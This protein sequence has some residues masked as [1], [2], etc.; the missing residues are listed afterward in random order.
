MAGP[1]RLTS[2]LKKDVS[3]FS[4]LGEVESLDFVVLR[5]PKTNRG[6]E[7]LQDDQRADDRQ[8]RCGSDPD[9]LID[10]LLDTAF[11]EAVDLGVAGDCPGREHSRE[12]RSD[13]ASNSVHPERIERV[14]VSEA[15]LDGCTAE[16]ADVAGNEPE[17]DSVN[18]V[19]GTSR[20]SDADQ[21]GRQPPNILPVCSVCRG[22][23]IPLPTTR[24]R[25]PLPPDASR[26]TRW[27]RRHWRRR[28]CRR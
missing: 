14:V 24:S 6:I 15:I 10:E 17:E 19:D 4:V 3:F 1:N 20:G 27:R 13:G 28:R 7:N 25:H 12:Q 23:A 21:T 5:N 2:I 9:H 16:E 26:Q 22:E 8:C 18:R 11:D